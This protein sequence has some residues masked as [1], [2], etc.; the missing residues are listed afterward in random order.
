MLTQGRGAGSWEREPAA[1]LEKG[2]IG[3][4]DGG[5]VKAA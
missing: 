5:G 2:L 3:A 1:L 4:V